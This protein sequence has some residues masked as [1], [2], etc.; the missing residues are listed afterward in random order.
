MFTKLGFETKGE[1]LTKSSHSDPAKT[2]KMFIVVD[3]YV[4]SS[5]VRRTLPVHAE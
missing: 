2:G 1:K 3:V 4:G 5:H